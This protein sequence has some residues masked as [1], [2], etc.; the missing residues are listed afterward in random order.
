MSG[1]LDFLRA[2]LHEDEQAAKEASGHA[3]SAVAGVASKEGIWDGPYD[4]TRWVND[5][6]HVFATDPRP[7][8]PP[9]VEIAY[10][11]YGAFTL[12]P[13]LARHD[14]ARVL[15][16]VEAKRRIV[17]RYAENPAEPWPL[18]PLLE[19]AAVYVDHPDYREEWK[20]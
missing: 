11:G 9:I 10:C 8:Q 16:E 7:E 19:M 6:D 17:S 4:G 14:P 18:F 12:T 1:L 5:Y 3:A 20:P 13:H 2:R 15:R